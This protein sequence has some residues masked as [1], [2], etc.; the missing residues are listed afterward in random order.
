M[1]LTNKW[2]NVVHALGFEPWPVPVGV[3]GVAKDEEIQDMA[4]PVAGWSRDLD[5]APSRA[6]DAVEIAS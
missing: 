5:S 1:W 3:F 4:Q 6:L 2:S